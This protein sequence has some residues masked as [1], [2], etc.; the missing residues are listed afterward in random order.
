[1]KRKTQLV[2]IGV[3]LSL[4]LGGALAETQPGHAAPAIL[5][6]EI[7]LWEDFLEADSTYTSTFLSWYRGQPVSCD[8][9]C[10]TQCIS[11]TGS[12]WTTCMNNCLASC[13]ATRFAAFQDAQENLIDVASRACP[14]TLDQCDAAR[15]RKAAC[16]NA[17]NNHLANPVRDGNGN[18]DM[19]WLSMVFEEYS[20]CTSASGI[21]MCE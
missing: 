17:Y 19:T 4:L 7:D 12:A 20:S 6:C 11:L 8:S 16:N 1:M 21:E 13:N 18:Y 3:V 10:N 9:Q 15:D 2:L 5:S 14:M